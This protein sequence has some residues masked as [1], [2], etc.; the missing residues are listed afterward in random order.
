MKEELL[1]DLV[2]LLLT[3]MDLETAVVQLGIKLDKADVEKEIDKTGLEQ[4]VSCGCWDYDIL[5][6][7]CEPCGDTMDAEYQD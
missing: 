6:E 2:Q 1:D 3:D 7:Y 5:D 4:C